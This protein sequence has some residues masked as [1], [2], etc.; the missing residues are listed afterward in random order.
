[1]SCAVWMDLKTLSTIDLG[2]YKQS[3]LLFRLILDAMCNILRVPLSISLTSWSIQ[4]S[5]TKVGVNIGKAKQ[6]SAICLLNAE[7]SD[8]HIL[9]TL[10]KYSDEIPSLL[11]G[12]L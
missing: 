11:T 4:S 7:S 5:I 3:M 8:F 9:C 1:M 10:L 6:L 12:P 2:I